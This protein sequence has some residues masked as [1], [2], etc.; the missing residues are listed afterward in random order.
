MTCNKLN[1]NINEILKKILKKLFLY[2]LLLVFNPMKMFS[3]IVPCHNG[4]KYICR[5]LYSIL[6]Q[7]YNNY[8]IIFINDGSEDFKS[9]IQGLI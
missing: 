5:C 8:E 3:I 2:Q 1:D 6:K 9:G 7:S 4:D